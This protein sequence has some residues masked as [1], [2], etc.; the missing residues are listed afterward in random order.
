MMFLAVYGRY[1]RG[2]TRIPHITPDFKRVHDDVSV[3]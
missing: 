3:K 1:S 2:V